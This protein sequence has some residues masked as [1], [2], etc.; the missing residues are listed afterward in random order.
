VS[1]VALPARLTLPHA[2]QALR[3]VQKALAA[4][5]DLRL[6]ASGVVDLDTSAVALLL[7]ARRLAQAAGVGFKIDTVPDKLQALARLYGVESLLSSDSTG[8][9]S[10]PDAAPAA[11]ASAA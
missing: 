5:G 4:G 1:A 9:A 11:G 3:D 7:Q 2:T 8:L 6:D 10:A